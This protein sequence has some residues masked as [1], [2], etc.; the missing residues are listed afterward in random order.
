MIQRR[1]ED[2]HH[3]CYCEGTGQPIC[4]AM[5]K[6]IV[7]SVLI[8]ALLWVMNFARLPCDLSSVSYS[9]SSPSRFILNV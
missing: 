5:C 1:N 8:C 9:T 4:C 7:S 6:R 3:I 2:E